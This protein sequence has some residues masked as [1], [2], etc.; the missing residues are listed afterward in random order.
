MM[1][2]ILAIPVALALWKV[3]QSR[4]ALEEFEAV[5][6]AAVRHAEAVK[7]A[8][9]RK[10]AD[11]LAHIKK[12]TETLDTFRAFAKSSCKRCYGKGYVSAVMNDTGKRTDMQCRCSYMNMKSAVGK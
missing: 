9:E 11:R 3:R 2:L 7:A 8:A 10:E 6:A 12:Y 4:H 1:W 5:E